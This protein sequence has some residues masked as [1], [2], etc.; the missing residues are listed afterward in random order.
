MRRQV[1]FDRYFCG[2]EISE[3]GRQH[4][5]VDYRTLAKSLD[6]K[7]TRLN[8]SHESESRM[9]SSAWIDTSV[10]SRI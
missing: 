9:P 1:T 2:N 7:S 4:G 6:R 3:Y 5:Y 8:S 10:Q